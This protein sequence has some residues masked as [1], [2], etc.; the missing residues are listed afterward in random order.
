M[1]Y[2]CVFAQTLIGDQFGCEHARHVTRRGGP[3]VACVGE[4]AAQR[5]ETLLQHL[6][7]T[8]LPAFD[9]EDDPLS[10]PHSVLVKIQF[11]G[12]LG[13]QRLLDAT[14]MQ[15]SAVH[16]IHA[17]L[18]L[19]QDNFGELHAIPCERIVT[20]MTGYKPRRRGAR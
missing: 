12:L 5:C 11:G 19:A 10:M 17:L 7:Q 15:A 1:E 2:K 20:D 6:K 14:Q 4:A 18:T 9:V 8:A 13:L 16:N 3:D